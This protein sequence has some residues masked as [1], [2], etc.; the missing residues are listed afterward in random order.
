MAPVGAREEA[1]MPVG[2][3]GFGPETEG[4]PHGGADGDG[5]IPAFLERIRAGRVASAPLNKPVAKKGRR[6]KA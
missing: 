4:D 3:P 1:A 6:V 2:G 5:E